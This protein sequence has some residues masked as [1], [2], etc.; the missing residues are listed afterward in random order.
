MSA[1]QI[2]EV[3]DLDAAWSDLRRLF[4]GLYEHHEALGAPPLEPD[5]PRRWRAYLVG[6][7]ERLV[8]LARQDGVAV[9]FFNSRINRGSSLYREAFGFIEDAYIC[10]EQRGSGLAQDLLQR[11]EDWCRARGVALLRLSVVANNALALHFWDKSG[12][13]PLMQIMSKTLDE[14]AT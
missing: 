6:P 3:R 1:I 4:L 9:G 14:A 8:L 2:E 11:T 5:W 10:P 12:F 7:E 13:Q